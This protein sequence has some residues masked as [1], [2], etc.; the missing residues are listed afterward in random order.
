MYSELVERALRTAHAAHAGQRRKCASDVPYVTHPMHVALVLARLGVEE[1][2]VAA[3]IL[4]D[5][6]EDCDGWDHA[7]LEREFG[8]EVAAIVRELTEDKS[9]V[10]EQRK[11][12]GI[13]KAR[14]LS[15]AAATVKAADKLHNLRTLIAELRSGEP[16]ELVWARFRGGRERTIALSAELVEALAERVAPDL[17]GALRAAMRE[18]AEL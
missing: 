10:W 7:R 9:R 16:A 18:L 13:A 1:H 2:V 8:G 12:Q 3:G 6:V 14:T 11:Q 17:G 5:V 15:A 4:H